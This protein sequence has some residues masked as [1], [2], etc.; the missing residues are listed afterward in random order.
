[1]KTRQ[2]A[3]ARNGTEKWLIMKI[4]YSR[5]DMEICHLRPVYRISNSIILTSSTELKQNRNPDEI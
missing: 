3:I 2:I 5:K 4:V 1:M